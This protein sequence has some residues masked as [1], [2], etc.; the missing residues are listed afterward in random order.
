MLERC[1][2]CKNTL[3]HWG[4]QC[5]KQKPPQCV[6]YFFPQIL[7]RDIH[8][9]FEQCYISFPNLEISQW[10]SSWSSHFCKIWNSVGMIHQPHQRQNPDFC[11]CLRNHSSVFNKKRW[12]CSPTQFGRKMGLYYL[13]Y[14]TK[15]RKG[16]LVTPHG[17]DVR[18]NRKMMRTKVHTE[19][20]QS[21]QWNIRNCAC[22]HVHMHGLQGRG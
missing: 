2:W 21:R 9:L 20:F 5:Q 4:P 8:L 6:T 7:L 17:L 14:I 1:Y 10:K 18:K 15:K 11:F 12:Y 3:S 22:L 16:K 13:C 19:N